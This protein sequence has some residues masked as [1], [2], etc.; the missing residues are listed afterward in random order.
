M[1]GRRYEYVLGDDL[2][3][4]D[5]VV[6]VTPRGWLGSRCLRLLAGFANRD[7]VLTYSVVGRCL[8]FLGRLHRLL[9]LDL[10][11]CIL[12]RMDRV[13]HA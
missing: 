1:T 7:C 3:A 5:I 2:G 10:C 12:E 9:G 8:R 6:Y 13:A 11:V 4:I